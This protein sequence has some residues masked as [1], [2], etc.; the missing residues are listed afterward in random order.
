M[1]DQSPADRAVER[2]A[3]LA[4]HS[5]SPEYLVRTFLSR[6]NRQAAG[7]VLE[8]MAELGMETAHAKDGT[9]RGILPG[10][11]PD[12]KPLILG[13]HIDTVIDAGKYDGPLGIISALAALET[14]ATEG[15][16]LPFPIHLLAFSD[17]EGV[18]YHTTYLGSRSVV[19]K[20]DRRTLS[21]VDAEGQSLAFTLATE[22]WH[23]NAT[24]F[25]YQP[26]DALAYVELHIEQGR[27]LE[28]AD[29]PACAVSGI[30]GQTRLEITLTGRADHAGTTPM[31][32]RRDAL[33]GASACI[34]AAEQ[35]AISNAPTIITVGKL[36]IHPGAS[37]SIPQSAVFSIDLRHPEDVHRLHE[38]EVL[39]DAFDNI[40]SSRDLDLRWKLIQENDATPCDPRYT[41]QMAT[42][43][44]DTTGYRQT[45][46]SGAGHDGVAMAKAMPVTMLFVRS[47][48]GLSHHPDEFTSPED[49]ASGITILTRFLKNFQP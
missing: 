34:L 14:L 13:S 18:R 10:S 16:S 4:S 41:E 6:A 35:Q 31:P 46:V 32:L 44:E 15:I 12:A 3:E 22:G 2:I 21:A 20:L 28:N 26:G 29:Q 33:A 30:V 17:E 24:V 42:A 37:N 43:V 36:Q 45:L 27:V 11:N 23:D 8:W 1:P 38:I 9:I 40:A 49:I 19:G 7:L 39:H 25:H 48:D 5:D 47:R